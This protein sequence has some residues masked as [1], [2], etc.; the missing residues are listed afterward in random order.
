MG[1]MKLG[2]IHNATQRIAS[3]RSVPTQHVEAVIAYGA[4]AKRAAAL[5]K[6]ISVSP[7]L[8]Q[9]R[10]THQLLLTICDVTDS[11]KRCEMLYAMRGKIRD[12]A[13]NRFGN[14]VL[15]RLLEKLPA[16]QCREVAEDFREEAVDM[17]RHPFGNHVLQKLAARAD[18]GDVLANALLPE[19]AALAQH[20]LAQHVIAS[21]IIAG[22]ASAIEAACDSGLVTS[23]LQLPESAVVTASLKSAHVPDD[24]QRRIRHMLLECAPTCI[25]DGRQHF[26]LVA[27]IET[28][29][30]DEMSAWAKLI[31]ERAP[32]MAQAK[33]MC[34]VVAA[35]VRRLPG[36]TCEQLIAAALKDFDSVVAAACHPYGSIVVREALS[37]GSV[38]LS[39]KSISQLV[40]AADHLSQDAAGVV[41]L[42]RLVVLGGEVGETIAKR[43]EANVE[44]LILHKS[45]SHALQA[46]MDHAQDE[47]VKHNIASAVISQIQAALTDQQGTYVAQ[48]AMAVASAESVTS[49][50]EAIAGRASELAFDKCGCYCIAG[51]LNAAKRLD[52]RDSWKPIMDAL[53]PL[54]AKLA[55]QPW[56]GQVVLDAMFNVASPE[57]QQKIREVIFMKCEMFLAEPLSTEQGEGKRPRRSRSGPK[58]GRA[59][60][61]PTRE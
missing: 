38:T 3:H 52:L 21:L 5:K 9:H 28:A 36:K 51:A 31:G 42:Q 23:L 49:A 14:I 55:T 29:P 33:G 46:V 30:Q 12:L 27:A 54:V 15:Q 34:A 48:K 10:E 19:L 2:F 56:T 1:G 24:T 8:A 45:G 18:A 25:D 40:E 13:R 39:K 57:L 17:A 58:E 22:N 26:A 11:T 37:A 20:T 35:V 59:P 7:S 60:K 53:K 41:V 61:Q 16:V 47:A 6:V 32:S 43:I 4:P 50:C 44:E